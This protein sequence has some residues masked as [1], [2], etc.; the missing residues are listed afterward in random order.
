M[1]KPRVTPWRS[2]LPEL[3]TERLSLRQWSLADLDAIVA[4]DRD[5]EVYRFLDEPGDIEEQRSE[6]RER[7]LTDFGENLGAWSIYSHENR[8]LFLGYVHL[9]PIDD[10]GPDVELGFRLVQAAWGRGLASEAAARAV[11]HGFET[12][13]LG[14]IIAVTDPD[15]AGSERTLTRLGFKREGWRRAW[16]YD[17]HF[18]RLPKQNW[19]ED[20]RPAGRR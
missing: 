7:I 3:E 20:Q 19:L 17:N 6:T 1:T 15:N 12:A 9:I 4:M 11:R 2:K 8:T 5:P 13:G 16:G 18:F 14:E 10:E